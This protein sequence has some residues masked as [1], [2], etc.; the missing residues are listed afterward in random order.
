MKYIIYDILYVIYYILHIRYDISIYGHVPFKPGSA[1]MNPSPGFTRGA[2][3][4]P[5]ASEA[6]SRA[7]ASKR[8]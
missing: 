7:A 8:L 2:S 4:P 5:R 3:A 1:N 6:A